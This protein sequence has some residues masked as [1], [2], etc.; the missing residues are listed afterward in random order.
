MQT[1]S[2]IWT[3]FQAHQDLI[4]T[5]AFYIL[6]VGSVLVSA[7]KQKLSAQEAILLVVN[8]LKNEEQMHAGGEVFK[9]DTIAKVDKVASAMSAGS[10][11][12][13]QVKAALVTPAGVTIPGDIKLGSLNGKPIYL[14]NVTGVGST[15]AAAL[16][17]LK[18]IVK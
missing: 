11:A 18:G 4:L 16:S 14:S 8:T 13:E 7:I 2:T 6:S 5:A 9:Q 1:L 12:V 17:V 3:F 15:L 10:T